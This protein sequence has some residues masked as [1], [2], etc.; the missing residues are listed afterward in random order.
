MSDKLHHDQ[1]T[2]PWQRNIRQNR[3]YLVLYAIYLR[4][5]CV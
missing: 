5:P 1:A 2:L 4:H 3:P